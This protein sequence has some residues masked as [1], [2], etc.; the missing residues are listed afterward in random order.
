METQK[1]DDIAIVDLI[2][3]AGVARNSFYRNFKSKRDIVAQRLIVLIQEW[4]REFE[5]QN[6]AEP[7]ASKILESLLRHYDKYR[8]FYLLIYRHGLS[9]MIYDTI[10]F[11]CRMDEAQNNLER[12]LKAMFA[13]MF[14]GWIDEWLRQGMPETPDEILRLAAQAN[15]GS[16]APV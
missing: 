9:D 13:G 10:R 7:D 14:W 5:E 12:Y 6:D 11:A 1:I 8:D 4:G 16:N 3:R 2:K 15:G